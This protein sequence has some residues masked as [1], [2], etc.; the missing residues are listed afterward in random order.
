MSNF[1]CVFP[2]F[3]GVSAVCVNPKTARPSKPF[4]LPLIRSVKASLI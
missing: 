1:R 3:K 4:K 2:C